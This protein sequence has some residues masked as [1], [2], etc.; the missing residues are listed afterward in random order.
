MLPY[1][2]EHRTQAKVL[3]VFPTSRADV[4]QGEMTIHKII[5]K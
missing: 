4:Y 3:K 1:K 2:Y 5:G